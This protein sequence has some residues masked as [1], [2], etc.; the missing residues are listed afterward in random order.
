M[1]AAGLSGVPAGATAVLA[2][3]DAPREAVL[4]AV[5][6]G[7]EGGVLLLTPPAE[8]ARVRAHLAV[9]RP[10][11]GWAVGDAPALPAALVD[12]YA[13]EVG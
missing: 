10:A 9:T 3:T 2:G 7:H 1:A 4:G 11:A 12:A 5:L 13:S 6:A 8:D